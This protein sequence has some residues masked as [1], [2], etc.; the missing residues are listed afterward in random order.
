MLSAVKEGRIAEIKSILMDDYS[1]IH[2]MTPFGSWLHIAAGA[3]QLDAA[4]YFIEGGIDINLK[5]G[6]AGGDSLNYAAQNGQKEMVCFLL[7]NGAEFDTT[8]P[9]RN[10]LFSAIHNGYTE[11]AKILI[12]AGIDTKIKYTG[13][14]MKNMGAL[15]FARERGHPDTIKYIESVVNNA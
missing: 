1:Y 9:E 4:K 15:E 2:K 13:Q 7:D 11:I 14:S 5:G 12:N 10:A 8:E 3:G 6:I